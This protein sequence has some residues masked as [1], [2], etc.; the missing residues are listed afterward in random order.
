MRRLVCVV[1]IVVSAV[2]VSAQA[3]ETL[4][5]YVIDVEGGASTLFVSPS[6]ES[7]LVD[8]GGS[9]GAEGAQRDVDRILEAAEDAGVTEIDH[10][11]VTHWHGDH[12]GGITELASRIPIRHFIDHGL[13]SAQPNERINAFL[14]TTYPE[15]FANAEHT[16]VRPGDTIPVTGL[17][18]RVVSSAGDV[19]DT[20]LAGAGGQNSLCGT[21]EPADG[22]PEDMQSVGA[23]VSYGSFHSLQLGDL[24]SD[25]EYAMVCPRNLIGTID[26]LLG[27]HHGQSTSTAVPFVHA[28]Q[29]RAAIM[30]NGTRKGGYPV[31]MRSLYSS[32]GFED[33]WQMHFSLLSGQEYAA[34]GLFI[35]NDV[36]EQ[37][38]ALPVIPMTAP[39]RGSDAPPPPVHSGRAYWV[40]VSAQQDGTFTI[41]NARNGFSK[42]YR[43]EAQGT[44]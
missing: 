6:G 11:L 3:R 41:T 14:A 15:L 33:L 16:V 36:D 26:V 34:P 31:V 19:L 42:V 9:G 7:L 1:A 5:I 17:D 25:K 24:T 13:I 40:K 10:V 44:R 2:L 39:A 23:R 22:F 37:P 32:S 29:P 20:P 21:P 35:A 28:I 30:N 12:V 8:T 4:D 43:P 27:L 18:V 38:S